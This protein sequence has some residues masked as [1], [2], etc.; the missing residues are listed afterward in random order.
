M[1]D[2]GIGS[3]HCVAITDDGE[4]YGWGRNDQGQIG[5]MSNNCLPE[6]TLLSGLDGKNIIGAACGPS[7]VT[8]LILLAIY[9]D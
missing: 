5:D 7:Q 6:P 8:S 9:M 3:M 4:V 1:R 2:I